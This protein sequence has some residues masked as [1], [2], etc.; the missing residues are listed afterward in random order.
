MV[1][2]QI[3]PMNSIIFISDQGKG[4][5]P[6]W[7]RGSMIQGTERC[8]GVVVHPEQEGPTELKLG[9]GAEVD[10]GYRASF[11]GWLQ[12]PERS[13]VISEADYIEIARYAVASQQTRVRIWLSHP[14]WPERVAIGLD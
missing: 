5:V 1:Q 6:D 2:L 9:A 11:D 3:S 12:T 7:V 13:V 14:T 4:S 10:P 8:I